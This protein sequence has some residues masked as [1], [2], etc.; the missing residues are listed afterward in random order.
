MSVGSKSKIKKNGATIYQYVFEFTMMVEISALKKKEN[1]ICSHTTTPHYTD[2]LTIN[3]KTD[4]DHRGQSPNLYAQIEIASKWLPD[5]R[6]KP[7]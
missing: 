2:R 6:S 5:D 4:D 1:R 3:T 7:T